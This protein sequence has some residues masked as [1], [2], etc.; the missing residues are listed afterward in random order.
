MG[1]IRMW[2]AEMYRRGGLAFHSGLKVMR[3]AQRATGAADRRALRHGKTT[4]TFAEPEVSRPSQ[5]DFVAL[6][7]DGR[8]FGTEA[9][10]FA[11]VYG[12]TPTSEPA[13]WPGAIAPDTYLENVAIDT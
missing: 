6:L 7:P 2:D 1:G 4:T 11:K 10:T 12:L 13:I 5:D 3:P 9:G 8:V